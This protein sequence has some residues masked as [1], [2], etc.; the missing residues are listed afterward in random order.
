MALLQ[1]IIVMI[2]DKSLVIGTLLKVSAFVFII[3]VLIIV[4]GWHVFRT[5]NS[6]FNGFPVGDAYNNFARII[7]GIKSTIASYTK[8][9]KKSRGSRQIQAGSAAGAPTTSLKKKHPKIGITTHKAFS[10]TLS[11]EFSQGKQIRPAQ[12]K[13]SK[14]IGS[15]GKSIVTT[16]KQ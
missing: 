9:K 7:N 4:Q 14:S 2:L 3:V 16:N 10:S 12:V 15:H 8:R 13:S 6:L 11:K 1:E 5:P